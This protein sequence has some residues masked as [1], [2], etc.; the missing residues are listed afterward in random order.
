VWCWDAVLFVF[1]IWY[2]K[3]LQKLH[4]MC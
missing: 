2:A 4:N 3:S 1:N